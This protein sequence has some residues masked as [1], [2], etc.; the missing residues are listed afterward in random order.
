MSTSEDSFLPGLSRSRGFGSDN[1]SGVHPQ[2]LQSIYQVNHDH[3]PSYGTDVF[4]KKSNQVFKSIFGEKSESY[5]VFTGTAANVLALQTLLRPHQ[6]VACSDCSHLHMDECGAPEFFT[7]GKLQILPSKDGKI[8]VDELKK[9]YIRQGDQHHSQLKVVSL[10]QPTELGTCYT[11]AEIQSI[12][13]WAHANKIYV[14]M[15][16]A[17]LTNACF[18]LKKSIK[19]LTSD[20]NIDVVSFG[21]SKN[22]LMFGEAVVFL[23]PSLSGDFKFIRKQSAQLPSKTRF[24]AAQ[25]LT[26]FHD[27]LWQK[28]SEN[29]INMAQLLAAELKQ[30][31]Q[32]EIQYPVESNAVFVKIPQKWIKPLRAKH[33][34]YVW[35]EHTFVCRLMTT[36]DTTSQDI[37]EFII[38]AKHIRDGR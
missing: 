10:T 2:I 19:E 13:A 35:D 15:D 36:W 21:G 23:N 28:I 27:H 11:V 22:G 25:F 5:F 17:R 12:V 32:L 4:S 34:F 9:I 18:F 31:S 7:R 33:F 38:E 30:I 29:S 1:H 3:C 16:G 8:T 37:T 24:I 20:L 26:F 14:H 6:S